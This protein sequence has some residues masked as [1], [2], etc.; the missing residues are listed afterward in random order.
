MARVG[1]DFGTTNTVVM[2]RDRGVFSEVQHRIETGAGTIVQSVFPSVVLIDLNTEQ[3]WYGIEADRRFG[4]RGP[5]RGHVFVS[6]LKSRLRDY[7]ESRAEDASADP[8]ADVAGLLRGFLESLSESI[9]RSLALPDDEPIE[10]V[11][12]WPANANGAQRHLTRQCFARAGY[13]VLDTLNEPTASAIELAD[14]LTA[15]RSGG[16]AAAP[17]AVAVFDL[18]G[19]TFDAAVVWI[20]GEECRVLASG[21]IEDLG[22]DNFDSLLMDM[23]F[24]AMGRSPGELDPTARIAMLRRTRAEKELISGGIVKRMHLSPRDFGLKGRAVSVEVDAFLDRVLP[25]LEPAVEV[26]RDVIEQ[27]ATKE[28]RLRA[29]GPLTVYL[30]GGSSR[31]PVVAKVVSEAFSE[32]RV[33]LGDKPFRSVAMGA[34]LCAT[35]P[36]RYRDVFARHFGLIRL[37]DHGLAETFDPIF[38]AGTPI[39]RKGEPPL[40]RTVRYHPRHNVGHL[41]Y[42]ECTSIH[43]GGL[44]AGNVRMWSDIMFPYDPAMSLSTPSTKED[45][46][47]TGAF[48]D[49]A[50]CE[51]YRCDSDGVITVELQRPARMDARTFEVYRD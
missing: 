26:L 42:L 22:G 24:D 43:P 4:Q 12:T 28:S 14:C 23:F 51:V 13:V 38:P 41:R 31:L 29:S 30:V 25:L 40:Q 5:G 3:R 20:E 46:V 47:G 35:E 19:G 1:I 6:S 39:P 27:A 33:V 48:A 49:E 21:G 17:S 11:I 8:T 15:G 36:V 18:G 45:V 2:A 16:M 44:P 34:A 32:D 9:R 10:A 7:V 50:V 37:R